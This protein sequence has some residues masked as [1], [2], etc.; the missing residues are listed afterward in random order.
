LL[1]SQKNLI[2]WLIGAVLVVDVALIAI[3]WQ[4]ITSPRAP[5]DTLMLLRRE[6]GLYRADLARAVQIR[7]QL[8]DVEHQDDE[9]FSGRLHPEGTGYSALVDDL[10]TLAQNS[11][12][13]AENWS[14]RQHD[15]DKR[16]V[17]QIDIGT[18]INGDYSSVVRF[19]DSLQRS[20]SFYILDGMSLAQGSTG[21]LRLNLQ[22]RTY[23][24]TA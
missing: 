4:M 11:G 21:Q 23:F 24:R 1:K 2:R 3:N 15:A 16:G 19:I 10:G 20:D 17:V 14:F 6:D 12:L 18:V 13:Q 8:P 9:F 7:Q 22:L 5:K